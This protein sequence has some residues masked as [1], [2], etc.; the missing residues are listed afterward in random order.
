MKR[1]Q[2]LQYATLFGAANLMAVG[3]HGCAVRG[4]TVHEVTMVADDTLSSE[5]APGR[6]LSP[7]TVP[8]LVVVL[9]RGAADGLNIVVPYQEQAYYDRRPGIAIAPPGEPDG[10]L[11]LDGTFGLHP[12]LADLLP[13]WNAGQLAFVHNSGLP[14][15]IRSHFEAQ[16]YMESGRPGINAVTDGWMNRLL[17]VIERTTPTQ[18]VS[19]GSL[20]P[21]SFLGGEAIA[22]V[23]VGANGIKPLAIDQRNLQMAFDSLYSG[24]DPLSQAYQQGRN[25]RALLVQELNSDWAA[26]SQAR[27]INDGFQ[28]SALALAQLMRGDAQTQVAFLELGGWDTHVNQNFSLNQRLEQLSAGLTTLIDGLGETYRHTTIVVMSEFGRT[29]AENGNRGTEHGHGNVMW[30][31]GGQIQGQRR[32]GDWAGL[33]QRYLNEGRD[34][35]VTTDYRDVLSTLLQKQWGLTSTQLVQIFPD[36]QANTALAFI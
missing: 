10:A 23:N 1:R 20:T 34:L 36:Y 24:S 5:T 16:D 14:D 9:L 33:E 6:S 2:I 18:A 22:N 30:L 11:D 15:P 25:T 32:Y 12:A 31:L 28:R 19:F 4:N 35:P 27:Q 13:Q 3:T 29:A 26:T 8:R 21:I 7:S 17:S